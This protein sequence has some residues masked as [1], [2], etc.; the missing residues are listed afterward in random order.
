[1][2][3]IHCPLA[4]STVRTAQATLHYA[5]SAIH[6]QPS[7]LRSNSLEVNVDHP[8]L[9]AKLLK[10]PC[11]YLN[12]WSAHVSDPSH[13]LG[14]PRLSSILFTPCLTTVLV[15]SSDSESKYPE[16]TRFTSVEQCDIAMTACWSLKWSRINLSV[17]LV[18]CRPSSCSIGVHPSSITYQLMLMNRDMRCISS[19]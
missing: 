17:L 19:L 13:T 6:V 3:H 14:R 4:I 1:M 2:D 11:S 12:M 7:W 8:S 5:K 18:M 15:T 16:G 10:I 9:L